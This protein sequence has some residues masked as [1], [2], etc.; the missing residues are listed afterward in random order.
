MRSGHL[1]EGLAAVQAV[2]A[3]IGM[4]MPASPWRALVALVLWRLVVSVRGYGYRLRDASHAA[5]QELTRIDVCFATAISLSLADPLSGQ[6]FQARNVLWSLRCGEGKRIARALALEV[7][8]QA[9]YGYPNW[10]RTSRLDAESR[11]LAGLIGDPYSMGWS[12]AT[13]GTAH[14]LA[15]FYEE[16]L[17][18]CNEAEQV[19]LT[20]CVGAN[21][22]V[23]STRL[24][25]LQALAHMGRLKELA[26]RQ[27][28]ALRAAIERG[29]L[30]SAVGLRTG[31]PNLVWLLAGD[32]ARA[33]HEVTEA[34]REWSQRGFHLEHFFELLALTQADLYDGEASAAY[35]RLAEKAA[36]IRR[37]FITRVQAVRISLWQLRARAALGV[38]ASDSKRRAE[39]LAVARRDARSITREDAPWARPVATLLGAG[40]ARVGGDDARAITLLARAEKEAKSAKLGLIAMAASHARGALVGGDEGKRLVGES[41]AWAAAQGAKAPE[42]IL[43]MAAPGLITVPASGK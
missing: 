18:R 21:W 43:A 6:V 30:Y 35:A 27:P 37:S 23:A 39:A 1:D 41:I 40:I 8:L 15:G 32:S 33:R 17:K 4:K 2:L 42:R 13:S 7:G 38:A 19:L 10:K 11:K 31:H 12:L 16:G 28:V 9:T 22:E 20:E 25:A 29:D 36:A 24:F 5:A 3:T 14:Y 34:I 26:E